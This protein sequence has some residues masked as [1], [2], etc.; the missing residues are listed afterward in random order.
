MRP[1]ICLI[2]VCTTLSAVNAF[3]V[4]EKGKRGTNRLWRPSTRLRC[5]APRCVRSNTRLHSKLFNNDTDNPK[6]TDPEREEFE[7][8]QGEEGAD[9][10]WLSQDSWNSVAKL[11]PPW[12]DLSGVEPAVVGFAVGIL[13]CLGVV[14]SPILVS[15]FGDEPG[16]A[17][18]AGTGIAQQV[19]LFEDVL[20]YLDV[21]YVDK[22]NVKS[23]F[24]TGVGAMLRSLDP[25]TEFENLGAN[26]AMQES[27][28]GHETRI[29]RHF[30]SSS[31]R[32][33]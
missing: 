21:G 17:A 29:P 27:V 1:L 32:F 5:H 2:C 28:S 16:S 26:R 12:L 22:V 8:D 25:Y 20:S 11:V 3:N 23:L 33:H 7:H 9:W 18:G 14:L 6:P 30:I 10:L 13:V 19:S 31:N 15:G 24:E 4:P